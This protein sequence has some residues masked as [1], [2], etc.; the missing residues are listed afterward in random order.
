MADSGDCGRG[1]HLELKIG[2]GGLS[3]KHA[4]SVR[5]FNR[6]DIFRDIREDYITT[7]R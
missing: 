6:I 3:L 7:Q 4:I 5:K 1:S 2:R